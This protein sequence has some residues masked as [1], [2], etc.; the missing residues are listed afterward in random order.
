MELHHTT[1]HYATRHYVALHYTAMPNMM[2]HPIGTVSSVLFFRCI[3]QRGLATMPH[4][5]ATT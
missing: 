4:D 5:L 2:L 1:R 3:N